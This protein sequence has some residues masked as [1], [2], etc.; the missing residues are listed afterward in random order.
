[1]VRHDKLLPVVRDHRSLQCSQPVLF[2]FERHCCVR[3][4]DPQAV[5]AAMGG[6]PALEP[7]GETVAQ[8]KREG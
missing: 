8:W 7:E 3:D 6:L 4:I 1:M 2:L 5:Y